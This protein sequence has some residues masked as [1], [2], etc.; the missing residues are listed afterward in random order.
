MASNTRDEPRMDYYEFKRKH[1]EWLKTFADVR[2]NV[3][4]SH[5]RPAPVPSRQ[6]PPED[7]K[8]DSPLED[9][10]TE[11]YLAPEA[12]APA[13]ESDTDASPSDGESASDASGDTAEP[14]PKPEPASPEIPEIFMGEEKALFNTA[15]IE[16]AGEEFLT[17][18]EL[19][20][21]DR[22][23]N[24]FDS[25]FR[26]VGL[27]KEKLSL[28]RRN[29]RHPE[30]SESEDE[31]WMED[32][33][34]DE[35]FPPR[36]AT[37]QFQ[38]KDIS[39]A[40]NAS[41]ASISQTQKLRMRYGRPETEPETPQDIPNNAKN[42]AKFEGGHSMPEQ[43]S[44]S[45]A[46]L[47]QLLAEGMSSPTLSRRE[48]RMI[49]QK[50]DSEE[51]PTQVYRPVR[52]ASSATA[53]T[54]RYEDEDEEE[55][56]PR[57]QKPAKKE[58]VVKGKKAVEDDFDD[59]DDFDNF[60]DFDDEPEEK[61]PAK[62]GKGGKKTPARDYDE[63]DDEDEAFDGEEDDYDDEDYDEDYDDEDDDDDEP[64]IGKR[65][66]NIIKG[67]LIVVLVLALLFVALRMLEGQGIIRL[68]GL[69]GVINSISPEF[70]EWLLP[71]PEA[72]PADDGLPSL[73]NDG[74]DDSFTDA[75]ANFGPVD[76]NA[77]TN[78]D[79]LNAGSGDSLFPTATPTTAPTAAPTATPT[80]APTQVPF[81]DS[82]LGA[83]D[84]FNV[85]P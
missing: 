30:E 72:T 41:S 81:D 25:L 11:G 58:K 63:E 66:L 5:Q 62:R 77:T 46:E 18:E 82:Q 80:A 56:L 48:R 26:A 54:D 14:A 20:A 19:A 17:E 74:F 64:S 53:R 51:S 36:N 65:I 28:L 50:N 23:P 76:E 60:D 39:Q 43:N 45:P 67:V 10:A 42:A 8:V 27:V 3:E 84:I 85:L 15:P 9:A 21:D 47:S 34:Q 33:E 71:E 59:F 68:T 4:D 38:A 83:E 79:G 29:R 13:S 55:I 37:A 22:E 31:E 6:P 12:P 44:K 16:K 61:A 1:D 32:S 2:R 70:A 57:K 40:L 69:R 24:P 35:T 49:E 73:D 7:A 78:T 75:D 52:E